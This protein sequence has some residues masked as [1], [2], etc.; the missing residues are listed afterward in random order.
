[1]G[2]ATPKIDVR[3]AVID[4][5]KV[6]LVREKS[7]GLW[8]RPGGFAD[9]G[10]SATE[11]VIKEIREQAGIR[12]AWPIRY[13]ALPAS[14]VNSLSSAWMSARPPWRS[15]WRKD[16]GHPSQGWRTFVHNHADAIASIDMFVV[17]TISFGLLYGLLI[18]QQSRRELLCLGVT[19][20]PDAEWLARQLTE[21]C[22]W[23][24]P[25]RYLIRDRDGAYGAAF[26]RRIRAMG[27]RDRPVS[28]RSPWQNG[29]AERLI[30]SIRRECLDH[31]VVV[32]ECHLRH[33]LASYQKYYNE[34][35]VRRRSRA[36]YTINMFEF[37]FPTG[38]RLAMKVYGNPEV[39]LPGVRA[40]QVNER[41]FLAQRSRRRLSNHPCHL[42]RVAPHPRPPRPTA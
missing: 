30:G 19:A 38:T 1:V 24:G 40:S 37:E 6:L 36:G 23:D 22:G 34:V 39:A 33:V 29:Y 11:N 7:D 3:G 41:L 8:T 26:I 21:A 9:V 16:D 15:P 2:Y 31:V 18:L 28:A 35:R 32:G 5:E 17:P 20:H 12:A 14:T 4:D 13:G 10:L 27:I 42:P 25:P